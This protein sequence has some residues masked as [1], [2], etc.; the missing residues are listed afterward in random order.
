MNRLEDIKFCHV[1]HSSSLFPISNVPVPDI[2]TD[3]EI[4]RDVL[5]CDDCE[6][7]HYIEEGQVSYEFSCKINV[8]TYDKKIKQIDE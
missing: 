3:E 5:M 1:C 7:L 4:R 2:F 6:T 8:P